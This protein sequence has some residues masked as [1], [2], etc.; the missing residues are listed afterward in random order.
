MVIK[1]RAFEY[2]ERPRETYVNRAKERDSSKESFF[3]SNFTFFLPKDGANKLRILP[4]TWDNPDHYGIDIFVH[5]KIGD[6]NSSYLCLKKMKDEPCPICEALS[7]PEAKSDKALVDAIGVKRKVL[8]WVIDRADE[9]A[10][11]K[12]WMMPASIDR[13]FVLQSTDEDSPS[14]EILRID[15]PDSGYDVSF[16]KHGKDL[17]TKYEGEK[18]ARKSTPL[19]S[20][21]KTMEKWLEFICENPLPEVLDFKEYKHIKKVFDGGLAPVKEEPEDEE[22]DVPVEKE[23]KSY[24]HKETPKNKPRIELDRE[25]LI[26]RVIELGYKFKDANKMS[27][28]EL[29]GIVEEDEEVKQEEKPEPKVDLNAIKERVKK[30]SK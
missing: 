19:S 12:L 21:Q 7:T 29:A 11:P 2:S 10:G 18:I 5:Y 8:V 6:S 17:Q 13:Q 3:K 20:D 25:E 24:T 9:A 4:P 28:E 23:E 30:Y 27:D 15:N 26:E 16:E 14:G 22:D 1:K